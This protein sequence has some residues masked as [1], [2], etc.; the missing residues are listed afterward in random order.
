[1][2]TLSSST[3]DVLK[4]I[5]DAAVADPQNIPGTSVAIANKNGDVL[6]SYA[7]GQTGS[8]TKT[9]VTVDNIYW[10]ASC[11]KISGSIVAMQAVEKGLLDLDSADDVEKYCPELKN[12]PILKEVTKDGQ[13]ILVPKTK[14]ITLRMLLTHTAGFGYSFFNRNLAK[15][16]ELFGIDELSGNANCV[17]LPL[18]FEPGSKWEYGVGVDWA[19]VLISRAEGVSLNELVTKNIF[20]PAGVKDTT[21]RPDAELKSRLM[22]MNYRDPSGKLT[23]RHH[24]MTASLSDDLVTREQ[25]IDSAGAGIFSRPAEYVKVL[26]VLLNKGIAGQT[27]KRILKEESV[28]EM[29]TN[30]IPQWPDFARQGIDTAIPHLSNSLPQIYPQDGNP[31]QGWGLSAFLN[32]TESAS[33]RSA[34]SGFWCGLANLYYWVDINNGITGMVCT[35]ILPFADLKVLTLF[36]EVETAVYRGLQQ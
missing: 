19:C 31:P 1:M 30:Q 13:V 12:L 9:P 36:A 35:Q 25:G 22:H 16:N 32:L 11:T 3:P 8:E 2:A 4:Q 10:I 21:M 23:E 18:L 5:I 17:S 33:G 14:R 34:G 15:Y 27:G 26:A 28:K 24:P 20:E 7:A 29:F 6:F